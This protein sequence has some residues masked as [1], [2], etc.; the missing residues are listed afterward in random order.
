M[1][2]KYIKPLTKI[3]IINTHQAILNTS[4]NIEDGTTG[5]AYSRRARFSDWEGDEE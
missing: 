5:R 2:K 1:K 3:V 4:G